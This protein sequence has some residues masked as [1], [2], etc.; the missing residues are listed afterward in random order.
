M[1]KRLLKSLLTSA[2]L[3]GL[4]ASGA[5][6]AVIVVDSGV[7]TETRS[8]VIGPGSTVHF[9]PAW[10]FGE[11]DLPEAIQLHGRFDASFERHW[12][13][14]YLDSDPT[15]EQGSFTQES[16]WLRLSNPALSATDLPGD[17]SFPLYYLGLSGNAFAG[18]DGACNFP[19]GPGMYCSG[20]ILF[21][22]I[23]SLAGTLTPTGLELE[24]FAST[25]Q[26]AGYRYRIVA[27][28]VPEPGVWLMFGAGLGLIGMLGVR[29]RGVSASLDQ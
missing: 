27:A 9:Q 5:A 1:F 17:F 26:L 20:T 14:Y 3:S 11:A 15:G 16:Y 22:S 12:W 6:S 24:G 23:S 19:M 10:V 18:N 21:G 25:G 4:L 28:P 7:D 13:S 29:K 2:A 8:Y